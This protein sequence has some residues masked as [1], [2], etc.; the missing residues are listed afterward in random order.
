MRRLTLAWI[1]LVIAGCG[2]PPQIT[3]D[4]DA[5]KEVDALYTAVT[6]KNPQLLEQCE[7]RL[8]ALRTAGKL[9]EPA[10]KSLEPIV[11]KAKAGDWRP[12][13]EQLND[14]MRGQ[15]RAGK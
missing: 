13:A 12:A 14:F 2:R 15:R 11:A 10:L 4:P 7:T 6:A 3:G 8:R 9:S 1:V 5:F